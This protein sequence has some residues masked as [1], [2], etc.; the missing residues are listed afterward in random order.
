M[1]DELTPI[2]TLTKVTLS[3]L[4]INEEIQRLQ[5]EKELL[6]SQKK[7]A[8]EGSK[9]IQ[10]IEKEIKSYQHKIDI[11]NKA[12]RS[13]EKQI[14]AQEK[15]ISVGNKSFATIE[16]EVKQ[17]EQLNKLYK[18]SVDIIK[19][20]GQ[21]IKD[22]VKAIKELNAATG[23]SDKSITFKSLWGDLK[24]L[25]IGAFRQN[26]AAATGAM[27]VFKNTIAALGGGVAASATGLGLL[28][29]AANKA[30]NTFVAPSARMRNVAG[31]I[32]GIGAENRN[33]F[34]GNWLSEWANRTTL[35]FSTEQQQEQFSGLVDVLRLNPGTNQSLYQTA[36]SGRQSIQRIW[37]TDTATLNR[38]DKAYR[39]AGRSVE[40]LSPKFDTL[41]RSLEGTGFTQSEFTNILA[42]DIMYLKNF[43]VNLDTYAQ[44]LKKYGNLLRQERISA[45]ALSAGAYQG[46]TTGNMAYLA[47]AMLRS[48]VITEK[49]LGAGLTSSITQQS[50]ALRAMFAGEKRIAAVQKVFRMMQQDPQMRN[51][52]QREGAFTNMFALKE[53]LTSSAFNFPGASEFQNI[54][55]DM[56]P[57]DIWNVLIS[58][59]LSST[60]GKSGLTD[61]T[62][63]QLLELARKNT[64]DT[65]DLIKRLLIHI[66]NIILKYSNELGTSKA[67]GVNA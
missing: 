50:G 20:S 67:Q 4:F 29:I 16:K 33:L 35:G 17:K 10:Q 37:G 24:S 15:L 40:Q 51:W 8:K 54:L 25:K 39:Q 57:K 55:K 12:L 42:K 11:Q 62:Q 32:L 61:Y 64:A 13:A 22:Q 27:G 18:D 2:E 66:A 56:A 19:K 26:F 31:Q 63:N 60:G 30:Y 45:A 47:Q 52:L 36:L 5:T 43:G 14:K 49:E 7:L 9:E 23:L 41:M 58:G 1:A 44:D 46:E 6:E 53:A 65:S 21:S 34:G 28:A 48:G 3:K 59:D 38:I